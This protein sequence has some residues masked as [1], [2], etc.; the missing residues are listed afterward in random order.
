M[1]ADPIG[2]HASPWHLFGA[3]MRHCRESRPNL[4][5]RRAASQMYTDFSNLAKWE[6]GERVPPPDMITRLDQV[7]GAHGILAALY[8]TLERLHAAESQR[9]KA[10]THCEKRNGD[11]DMERRAA[12][13]FLAGLGTLSALGVSSEPLRQLLDLS[14]GHEHRSLED[15]DR[16]CADH[17]HALR[18]RPPA[19]VATDLLID[20]YALRRQLDAATSADEIELQ[21]SMAVLSSIHAIVLTYLD[22]HGMAI[23]WWRTARQAADTSGDLTLRLLVRC[24]EAGHGLYGQRSPQSVLELV[25]RAQQLTREPDVD[26]MTTEAKALSMLGRNDQ[27]LDTLHALQ[28]IADRDVVPDAYGFWTPNRIYFTESWVYAAAGQDSA[29]ETAR[30]NV[31]K[32]SRSYIHPVNAD[33]HRALCTVVQGGI[34]EGMHQAATTIDALKPSQRIRHINETGHLVLRA[35]PQDQQDRPSVTEFRKVLSLEPA[36]GA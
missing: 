19:Q 32:H 10:G 34:D 11:D 4:G 28:A 6:R 14:L 31:L 17:L 8:D 25:R 3:V 21:R 18:T 33:L 15:W 5:L 27:A 20:L 13:Q 22:D 1:S 2:P 16:A 24:E 23:R 36:R 9:S 30:S 12:L 35:V 7:Y 29:A 26:L